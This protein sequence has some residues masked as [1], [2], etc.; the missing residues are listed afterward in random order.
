MIKK[1]L[2]LIPFIIST[3]FAQEFSQNYIFKFELMDVKIDSSLEEN[4]RNYFADDDSSYAL[5]SIEID[6][7]NDGNSEKFIPNEFLCGSGGCP[8]LIYN[9][10]SRKV[11]GEIFGKVLFINNVK[12]ND[13]Y[14]IEVYSRNGGGK[15]K[16]NFYEYSDGNY[17]IVNTFELNGEEINKYFSLKKSTK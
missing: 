13:Y 10:K 1:I 8:W 9:P 4:I 5:K 17:K 16:V 14:T 2:I 15:G 3:S 12:V 6:L 7:N 11:I